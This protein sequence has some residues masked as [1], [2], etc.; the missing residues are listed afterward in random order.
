M[1]TNEDWRDEHERKYPQWESD[2]EVI[3]DK[4]RMLY[5]LVAEKL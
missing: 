3:S 4:S 5:A 1:N 2:I